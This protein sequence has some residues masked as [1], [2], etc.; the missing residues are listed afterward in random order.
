MRGSNNS[1]GVYWTK[2]R[3]AEA[4]A[5]WDSRGSSDRAAAALSE[6]WGV[7]VSASAL[8]SAVIAH[9]DSVPPPPQ[10]V[11][12]TQQPTVVPQPPPVAPKSFAPTTQGL[13]ALIAD[14][15][16]PDHDEGCLTAFE[17]W[18]GKAK[19]VEIIVAGDFVE[20]ESASEHPGATPRTI[21][22]DIAAGQAVMRR[23]LSLAPHVTLREGNHCTRAA[24]MVQ[25]QVPSLASRFR[26]PL[27]DFAAMGV[28]VCEHTHAPLRRGKL[29]V[30]HG[31][32][33]LKG[34]GRGS[35]GG[36][37]HAKRLLDIYAEPGIVLAYGHYHRTQHFV[38]AM[39]LGNA[40]AYC[41]PCMRTLQPGWVGAEVPGWNQGWGAA[42]LAEGRRPVLEVVRYENG[43]AWWGGAEV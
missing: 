16:V 31:D 37:Y 43:A 7:R 19:P 22:A 30:L 28:E 36:M 18:A 42:R 27:E 23:L 3:V 41:L 40:D 14:L 10:Q 38:K 21:D 34:G 12:Y 32:E 5:E 26:S 33:G 24:R 11:S 25:H 39:E 35:S 20:L 15:H 13:V 9:R 4:V 17:R 1:M 6:R 8:R 29:L 2:E